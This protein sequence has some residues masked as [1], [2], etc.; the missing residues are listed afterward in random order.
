[1][2]QVRWGLI[3]P[4]RI[5]RNFADGLKE[6][7]SGRLQAVAS[8]SEAR[9]AEFGDRYGIEPALRFDS[10]EAMVESP[11]IDAVYVATPHPW[12]AEHAL[13]ALRAGKA[14][15]VEKPMGLN[16]AEV[17]AVTEAA[18]QEGVFLMEGF[19]YR[20]H[21][22][23][24][25]LVELIRAGAIGQVRHVRASFGFEARF[26]PAS[27][28]F[29]RSLAGGGILDVG[30]YP[31]SAVRLVAGAAVGRPFAEPE[32]V[33]GSG[34]LGATRV[35][36]V[37]F[38][39][40]TFPGGITAEVAC[41]TRRAMENALVVEGTEGTI[42]LPDPWVPGRNAGPSDAVIRIARGGE[43]TEEWIRDPRHLFAFE[44]EAAS[45]AIAAGET[46]APFPA[47]TPAESRGNAAVLDRW[48][49]EMGATTFAE[50]PG[51]VRRLPRALPRG[52]PGI[53]KVR[54]PG[55]T[56]PMSRL[57][58]GCDNRDT[59]AE[60][61]IV[62]DAWMEA[63]GNA[64]DTAFV[65]GGGRHE[66]VLGQWI[67]SR[68][69]ADEVVVIAKGAHSPYC[70]PRAIGAQLEMSLGRLGLDRVPIYVMHRDNP[71]V[72]VGEFVDAVNRLIDAGT[73][74]I[75]GGSNWSVERLA[76]AQDHA[77][78][79][80]LVGPAILS[81][82]LSLAVMEKPVWA[83]CVSSN[84]PGTLAVLQQRQAIHL[85]WS[86]QARGYFLPEELR[87]R[88]PPDTR[89]E[90]CFGS[91]ANAERRRRAEELAAER[92]VSANAVALAWVLAQPFPSLA[93]VGPRS[94]GEIASSLPA[95][96]L[97]LSPEEAAWLN[98]GTERRDR[99]AA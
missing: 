41:A 98:L 67:A 64:F 54:V 91:D 7:A 58:I 25:R 62:W 4:G 87:D 48:R 15:L 12:H 95:L 92:G 82:N 85:S 40:L 97:N 50:D 55:V 5:A 74:G 21:P 49:Q 93:L 32:T 70:T 3:G 11:D 60:G 53:G 20:C 71:D 56:L 37:A 51:V 28:L 42:T 6:A 31:V 47:M 26:D 13:L 38:A 73:V 35:D 57:V 44:A 36:E 94:P 27:R 69:V 86:S 52:L 29:D 75:W 76:E 2:E 78:A 33:K 22:Q 39:L 90:T 83:G 84:D 18:R 24:A 88:L 9:R 72:P 81:N 23:V 17:V 16:L 66:G 43:T 80:G 14:A 99:G 19:M 77:A 68:G 79:R 46:E 59:P 1:M 30:G 89:P 63:G 45:R 34:L 65:Y 10:Y 61:A 8:R 96:D